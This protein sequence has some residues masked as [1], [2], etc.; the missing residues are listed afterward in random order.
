VG[1][2]GMDSIGG[3]ICGSSRAAMA[4][5]GGGGELARRW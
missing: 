5:L 4:Q 3:L 2:P 1:A